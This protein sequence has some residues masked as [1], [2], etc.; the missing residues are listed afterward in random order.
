M[1][2]L[3]RHERQTPTI[4]SEAEARRTLLTP[5]SV[6]REALIKR[7]GEIAS[8]KDLMALP[9]CIRASLHEIRMSN[10]Y[11]PLTAIPTNICYRRWWEH[12]PPFAARHLHTT[13][14]LRHNDSIPIQS[15]AQKE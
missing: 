12:Q 5:K 13:D 9:F 8:T 14:S 15:V 3:E 2:I 7:V 1:R 11:G 4:Y 10:G 6:A